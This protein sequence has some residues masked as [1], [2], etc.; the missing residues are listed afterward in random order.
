[1]TVTPIDS[2]LH[3]PLL[4]DA[5][6]A[7]ELGDAAQLRA[8]LR[9]EAALALVQGRLGVIP[10]EAAA[11]ISAV[12]EALTPDPASL[13]EATARDGIPVPA[14]V[15]ALRAAA[16]GPAADHAHWGA[17]SQ[18]VIDTAL[19]LRLKPVL[20]VFDRRL[21]ALAQ[22]LAALADRH[23]RTLMV[24]RTRGQQAVPTTFGLK[25]AVWLAPLLRARQRLDQ[26]RPRLLLLSF[27]GAAGTLAALGD[28]GHAVAEALAE[29]LGL[30]LPPLPWH[31]QRDGLAE[32]AGWLSLVT[33]ALGK[34]GQDVLLLAQSEVAEL[35]EGGAPGR[36][37]SS[38]MPNKANPVASGV[39]VTAARLNASL[40]SALHQALPQ[41]QER[42][43][44]GWQLEW[45]TLPQ[46]LVTAGCALRHAQA[47]LET[48]DVDPAR[49][50]RNLEASN[51]LVLAEAATFA[52]AEH[53]SRPQAQDLVKAAC[54][55]AKAGGRHLVDL[56][57][58]TTD[59]PVE[60]AK[61]R[62]PANSLGTTETF[63]DR[64]LAEVKGA[65]YGKARR[66]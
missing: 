31:V 60:W 17:T 66:G 1:M 62:D 53:L 24:A 26:L 65:G 29:E 47:L 28:R 4:S 42:G 44:P 32:L 56:L 63:I 25:A 58:E 50:R 18:D 64:V 14:L 39:L 46:M 37:G 27:G 57:A 61:L 16:G 23:R 51:G 22:S 54:A 59:A 34:L 35:R 12:A 11:R 55:E 52:L 41:E 49:M 7:A 45:L 9:V 5:E 19:V 36:G 33:G 13:A 40:V 21:A 20:D 43:G 2:A 38:T 3:G 15:G 30:G 8:M 48:L 6:V 10:A